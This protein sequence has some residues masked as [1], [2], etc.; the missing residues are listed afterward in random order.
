MKKEDVIQGLLDLYNN[1]KLNEVDECA[2]LNALE[3]LG[4]DIRTI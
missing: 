3:Y 2:V 1:N 4:H